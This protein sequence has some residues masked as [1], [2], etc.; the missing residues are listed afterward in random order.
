MSEYQHP[1]PLQ[2]S[3]PDPKALNQEREPIDWAVIK[4][5]SPAIITG[6]AALAFLGFIA[7]PMLFGAHGN[8]FSFASN[9]QFSLF[10]ACLLCALYLALADGYYVFGGWILF[11]YI[12]LL[13]WF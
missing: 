9:I 7:A 5:I 6:F 12:N 2:V 4:A 13:A 10:A 3:E 1:L 8:N 11:T